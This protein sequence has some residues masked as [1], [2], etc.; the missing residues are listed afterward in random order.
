LSFDNGVHWQRFQ[1]NLPG[2]PVTDIRVHRND[3]V[4]STMGRSFWVMDNIT[5]LQQLAGRHESIVRTPAYLFEPRPAY[6]MRYAANAGNPG[7]PE[8]PPPGA[9]FDY[10]LAGEPAEPIALEIR[11]AKGNEVRTIAGG[12]A[13]PAAVPPPQMMMRRGGS[14]PSTLSR[15]AWHSRFRWDL[16]H[17]A[18]GP[19]VVP[20]TY[21][22]R[23]TMGE[24]SQSRTIEVKIDPR[25]AADNVRQADLEEQFDLSLKVL[26]AQ[27]EA[28]ALAGAL[29]QARDRFKADQA[30]LKVVQALL[31]RV[32]TAPIIYP[33]PMLIDQFS[34]IARMIGQ[35]DQKP[36][37]DAWDRYHDLVKEMAS[38]KDALGKL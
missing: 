9:D 23:L 31:D 27:A 37:K 21:N 20:G 13:A 29:A 1:Q 35:A 17:G 15:K 30:K 3:L 11:D 14:A 38:I 2:T 19:V 7:E 22:V 24:W 25:V 6:R 16:R 28:R 32:V 10:Y 26:E 12:T 5:P 34:S 36:G 4:L 8:F 33:Q 18:G